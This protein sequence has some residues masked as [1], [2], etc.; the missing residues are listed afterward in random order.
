MV[1]D[2]TPTPP[3]APSSS[4]SSS[5]AS[6]T[7]KSNRL[8]ISS[9]QQPRS[10]T[11]ADF[12]IGRVLGRGKFG[13]VYLAREKHSKQVVALKVLVKEQLRSHGVAHQLRKEVEIHSRIRHHNILPLYATF[14]DETRVFLVLK[15]AGGGDLYKKLRSNR[16]FTEKEAA[17]YVAQLASALEA[18]HAQ[19]VIHRDIKPENLLLSDEGELLLADFGWSS[20]NVTN[21]NRRE[22][23]CGTLDYLSPEMIRGEKYNESVDI[24]A[25][26]IIMFE[27]LVGKPP[28]EAPGQDETIHRI[29]DG[30][31]PV[32]PNLSIA[33]KDLLLR[34]LQKDPTKRLT[35]QKIKAHRW[36]S[37]VG[38]RHR[39]VPGA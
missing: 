30:P 32:P 17:T 31:L 27:L 23:L 37:N 21:N 22:T 39:R 2:T 10:W 33:A 1:A 35:L 5:A 18:C 36:F 24:W 29:T 15:H 11:L 6:P 8:P 9:Q 19:H 26:G 25:L 4:S 28:F 16:R 7:I 14:Q 13:Q 20:S 12:E 3:P 34:I 38:V